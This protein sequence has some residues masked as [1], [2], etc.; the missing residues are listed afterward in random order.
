MADSQ[1][2]TAALLCMPCQLLGRAQYQRS[3]GS[4]QHSTTRCCVPVGEPAV[5]QSCDQ[6]QQ[7]HENA[8]ACACLA[9]DALPC[10]VELLWSLNSKVDCC[11]PR[12]WSPVAHLMALERT[13]T[14]IDQQHLQHLTSALALPARALHRHG[15]GGPLHME[16][17]LQRQ[18]N[19]CRHC[20]AAN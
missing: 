1:H 16:H 18:S 19:R 15:A 5:M 20:C 13:H 12:L 11:I 4:G 2:G 7:P 8:T 17:A 14:P 10:K 9:C 6:A 3:C